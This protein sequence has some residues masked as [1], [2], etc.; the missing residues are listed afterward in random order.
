MNNI[1]WMC[2]FQGE[3]DKFMPELNR[4]CFK[5]WKELNSDYCV[6]I[7]THNTTSD[8]VPEYFEIIKN[9]PNR[10]FASK[11]DLLRILLLSKFGGTWVDGSVYPMK[12]LSEFRNK[13]LNDT[14]F[15]AYR[16]FQYSKKDCVTSSWFLVVDKKEHYLVERWKSEFIRKFM[17]D[18]EWPSKPGNIKD[19]YFTFHNTL[20]ELYNSDQKIS[21]VIDNMVQI[22]TKIPHSACGHAW[23]KFTKPSYVYKRPNIKFVIHNEKK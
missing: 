12:P 22:D 10:S 15:F 3:D 13:I 9:S 5:K 20:A 21:D 2:W 19:G 16:T 17:A 6:N 14:G 7:L 11:S 1:I 18:N 8:F 4:M 23:W